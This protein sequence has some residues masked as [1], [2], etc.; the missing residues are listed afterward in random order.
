MGSNILLIR[1]LTREKRHWLNFPEILE[2]KLD[3]GKVCMI[4]LPGVGS[5]HSEKAPMTIAATMEFVRKQWLNQKDNYPDLPWRIVAVSLG[6]MIGLNWCSKYDDFEHI[7]TINTS[8]GNLSHPL[9]RLHPEA[10]KG[11][12]RFFVKNDV[13]QREKFILDQTTNLKEITDD[14]IHQWQKWDEEYPVSRVVFLNQ[15]F[16]ASTFKVPKKLLCP[17]TVLY[18]QNDRLTL[19]ECSQKI[20]QHFSAPSFSHES[21]GHDLMLDDPHWVSEQVVNA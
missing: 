16:A 14:M 7:T 19:C 10:I 17:L 4:D 9:R 20:A 12:L 21:A 2:Q 8:A 13:Y 3:G 6:G 18:A 5:N 1:G 15:I 11:I